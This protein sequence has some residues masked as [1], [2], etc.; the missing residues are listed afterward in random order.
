[1]SGVL[2]SQMAKTHLSPTSTLFYLHSFRHSPPKN[3]TYSIEYIFYAA[4]V[5][6]LS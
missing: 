5:F 6:A 4:D 1:M 2:L 3:F